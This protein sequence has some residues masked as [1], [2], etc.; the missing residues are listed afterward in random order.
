MSKKATWNKDCQQLD[1]II[2]T[3][4]LKKVKQFSHFITKFLRDEMY[5]L[6]LI[7]LHINTSEIKTVC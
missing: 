5:Y 4:K 1:Y 6:H 3:F 7:D 2:A